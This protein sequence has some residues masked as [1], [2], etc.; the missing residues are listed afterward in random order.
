L[1][2]L[3][4]GKN[5]GRYRWDQLHKTEKTHCGTLVEINLHREFK[6]A[7]GDRLDYKIASVEVDCKYSQTSGAWMIPPEACGAL[8]MV[9]W[10]DDVESCWSLGIVRANSDRLNTGTNRD[11][12]ATLNVKGKQAIRWLF[13]RSALPQNL[14]LH[15]ERVTVDRI[16]ALDS[17]QK[18]VNEIFRVSVGKIV[19]R[20]VVATLAQQED[21]MKRI[22]GNGG[23]RSA[24]RK[25]GLIILGQYSSHSAIARDLRLPVPGPGDSLSARV[26]PTPGPGPAVA[27]I[28]GSYWRLAA[29]SDEVVCAPLLPG[30]RE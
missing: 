18:R 7:D 27:L 9:V 24:L 14:L 23:A 30:T 5:T 13:Q 2:Q 6:F 21:Y 28:A 3:Y 16:M 22:R 25:E 20:G 4:D 17:G 19:S 10:A 12:K 26:V 29:D 15:L 11:G 8:C 1:D